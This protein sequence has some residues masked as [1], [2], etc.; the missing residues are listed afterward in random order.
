MHHAM[1]EDDSQMQ[2][3]VKETNWQRYKLTGDSSI[4]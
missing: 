4:F 3:Y 1:M 2:E